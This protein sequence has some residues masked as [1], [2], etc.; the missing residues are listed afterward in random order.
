MY[1]NI[2]IDD[3]DDSNVGPIIGGVIGGI[4][5]VIVLVI[6]VIVAYWLFVHKKKGKKF[7]YLLCNIY[8]AV[9]V[10]LCLS[11]KKATYVYNY[12]VDICILII[13]LYYVCTRS[14]KHAA[15][16]QALITGVSMM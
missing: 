2:H 4:I 9:C 5:T 12:H 16:G 1:V 3:D 6:I 14:C 10:Q 7:M 13:I 8:L 15:Q 11:M